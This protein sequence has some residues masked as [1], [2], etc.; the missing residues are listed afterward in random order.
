MIENLASDLLKHALYSKYWMNL[1]YVNTKRTTP[2][3]IRYTYVFESAINFTILWSVS[4][5]QKTSMSYNM[6]L[7]NIVIHH[8]LCKLSLLYMTEILPGLLFSLRGSRGS[9]EH[10]SRKLRR[11]ICFLLLSVYCKLSPKLQIYKFRNKSQHSLS[12]EISRPLR[13]PHCTI[14]DPILG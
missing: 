3:Y 9:A 1:S 13:L 12:I 10:H 5:L 14:M 11:R 2:M 4:R 6:F 8:C 7:S